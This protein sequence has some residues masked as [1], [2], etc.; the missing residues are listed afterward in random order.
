MRL[1]PASAPAPVRSASN[2]ALWLRRR[3]PP[4]PERENCADPGSWRCSPAPRGCNRRGLRR[5]PHG[6]R[7][8]PAVLRDALIRTGRTTRRWR[9]TFEAIHLHRGVGMTTLA[10]TFFAQHAVGLGA[11][12]AVDAVLEAVFVGTDA[13]Q[14]GL[15]ALVQNQFH[16]IAAHQLGGLDALPGFFDLDYGRR[17]ARKLAPRDRRQ[18]RHDQQ[19]DRRA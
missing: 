10:E 16:M 4:P 3:T 8:H 1:L 14:H 17:G 2:P 7:N 9:M 6:F 5:A 18:S 19:G 15:I 12:M 13:A 11:R